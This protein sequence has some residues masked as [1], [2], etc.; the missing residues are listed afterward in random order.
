MDPLPCRHAG[1]R[2]AHALGLIEDA[3]LVVEGAPGLGWP[4]RRA[5]G[6]M[7][8]AL[9][10]RTGRGRCPHHARPDRLPHPPGLRR[11]PR[12]RVRAAFAGASYEEIARAGGG[13]A[14]TVKATRAASAAGLFQ[15]GQARARALMAEGVTTVEIKSGYGLTLERERK[16]LQVA[17]AP[18]PG[19]PWTCAPRSW[20]CRRAAGVR[21]KH[22]RLRR[23]R[24]ADA[25][26]AACRRPG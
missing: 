23:R 11:Q 19:T 5:T 16:C 10:D 8:R 1:C 7:A 22:G 12:P 9:H 14:S 21:R 18:G 24:A 3:A 4:A 25:A 20:A 6:R 17:R 26:C 15:R 13:I 2:R